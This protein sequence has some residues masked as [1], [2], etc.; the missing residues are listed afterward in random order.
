MTPRGDA[1]ARSVSK[2]LDEAS[3]SFRVI[4]I[5][6]DDI[7]R[8]ELKALRRTDLPHKVRDLIEMVALSDPGRPAHSATPAGAPGPAGDRRVSSRPGPPWGGWWGRRG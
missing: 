7:A 4:R 1:A 5:H 8:D 6:H 2:R 3:S